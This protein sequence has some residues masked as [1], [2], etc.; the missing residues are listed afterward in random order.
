MPSAA[1]TSPR[2]PR[3]GTAMPVR[4][5]L[6]LVDGDGVAASAGQRAVALEGRLVGEGRGREPLEARGGYVEHAPGAGTPCRA[7]RCGQA[8]RSRS[9][10][11]CRAGTASRPARPARPARRG[12]PRGGPS[13]GCRRRSGPSPAGRAGPAP[14]TGRAARR[15]ARTGCRRR[16]PRCSSRSR[17]P[18]RSRAAS[19][20]EV[21]DFGEPG[22][23]LQV[24]EGQRLVGRHHQR[25]E[26]DGAVDCLGAARRRDSL[27]SRWGSFVRFHDVELVVP[28]D[29][30]RKEEPMFRNR[31]PATRCSPRTRWPPS[32]RAGARLIT[33]I[34]VEFIDE[35]ALDLFR[36]AGQKVEDNMRLPRPRLRP[37]AGR[38]GAAR[39]RPPGA[40]PREHRAHRRRLDGLRRGLRAAV[41]A[42][43]RRTP[44]RH[45][46]GLPQLHQARPDLLGPRLAPA[47]WSTS[48][49][50]PRSTAATST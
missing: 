45:D 35:R 14:P 44:R 26:L 42:R 7:P 5:V 3:T 40:Q 16:R 10:R 19:I 41:R 11:G 9:S 32:T 38:Q 13:P 48:R 24:G 17:S 34:G 15:T 23:L 33:E 30:V 1:T 28:H 43:G 20:R 12:S 2:A 29:E 31:C 8:R 37:R 49:T 39:V 46:G 47:G 18:P 6:E 36:K 25:H 50:T 21:V 22:G 27:I 4:P